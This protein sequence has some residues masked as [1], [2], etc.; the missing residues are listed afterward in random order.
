MKK[1]IALFILLALVAIAAQ[2]VIALPRTPLEIL[3][4][5][6]RSVRVDQECR[7][8]L[9]ITAAQAKGKWYLA[10]GLPAPGSD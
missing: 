7:D 2:A 4:Y 1:Q 9:G 10:C 3:E 6:T 8:K 5:V